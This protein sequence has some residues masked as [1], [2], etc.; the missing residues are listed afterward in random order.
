MTAMIDF[1]AS[2]EWFP[3]EADA[4]GSA[5]G[6]IRI[7]E[8]SYQNAAFLDERML[9]P[10]VRGVRLPWTEVFRATA[11]IP[12]RCDF[13]F[14]ISHVG[15]TLL[16]RLLGLHP[17]CFSLR[18]PRLLRNF[19]VPR[20]LKSQMDRTQLAALLAMWSRVWQPNQRSLIKCTSIVNAIAGELLDSVPDAK[21]IAMWVP[22]RTFLAALL[23]GAMS[24]ITEHAE[25][26]WQRLILMGDMLVPP[27]TSTGETVAMSW[28]AEMLTLKRV[29]AQFPER[30]QWL[31]FD[32]YLIDPHRHLANVMA[33]YGLVA[34]DGFIA[35]TLAHPLASAY[36]KA[37]VYKFDGDV[38]AGIIAKN[39]AT[40][41]IEIDRGLEWLAKCTGDS[42]MMEFIRG[43]TEH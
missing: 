39:T 28:L 35:A 40:H 18:E 17:G 31:N 41:A 30:L 38:R 3:F 34:D 10:G 43:A 12:R 27:P 42:Q 24:D 16:A 1:T 37:T 22:A 4:G 13:L 20:G 26:R 33:H 9:T 25:S 15:S 23:G 14:H 36:A 21:A 8:S 5:I 7:D 11:S 29:A 2:P 32:D 6:F 19:A